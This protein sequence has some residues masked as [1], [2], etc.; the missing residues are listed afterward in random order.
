MNIPTLTQRLEWERAAARKLGLP[1]YGWECCH[2]V[3]EGGRKLTAVTLN[4]TAQ[5]KAVK[6]LALRMRYGLDR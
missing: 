2:Y 1:E 5:I 6:T 3:Q 4:P